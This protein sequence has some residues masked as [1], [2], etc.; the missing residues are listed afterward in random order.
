MFAHDFVY[1]W[2]LWYHFCCCFALWM[3]LRSD[4]ICNSVTVTWL[5]G[6]WDPWGCSGILWPWWDEQ[7]QWAAPPAVKQMPRCWLLFVFVFTG[8]NSIFFLF[9]FC[10]IFAASLR[11]GYIIHFRRS[12]VDS[13]TFLLVFWQKEIVVLFQFIRL[14]HSQCGWDISTLNLFRFFFSKVGSEIKRSPVRIALSHPQLSILGGW[15][16]WERPFLSP[17]G[18]FPQ[19]LDCSE[20]RFRPILSDVL[21]ICGLVW[22]IFSYSDTQQLI[23]SQHWRIHKF[24]DQFYSFI[25]VSSQFYTSTD[26]NWRC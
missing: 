11:R 3:L 26:G 19:E 4:C 14:I 18:S 9:G 17:G 5:M 22:Q 12:N 21:A 16:N 20:I 7:C 23:Q 1:S 10:F 24:V 8:W 6:R 25:Y 2:G 13:D 15:I